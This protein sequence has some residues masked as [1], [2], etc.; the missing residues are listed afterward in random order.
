MGTDV[1]ISTSS[2]LRPRVGETV[3]NK[4]S[5]F[6]YILYRCV[7]ACVRSCVRACMRACVHEYIRALEYMHFRI[8]DSLPY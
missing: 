7:H 6:G 4:V 5:N 3:R 2:C 8:Y 1:A